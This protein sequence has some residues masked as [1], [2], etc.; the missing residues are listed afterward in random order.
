MNVRQNQIEIFTSE[1]GQTQLDVKLNNETVWLSQKELSLL[2]QVAVSTIN[3][4]IKNIFDEHELEGEAT[5]RKF[6]IVQQE[7]SRQVKREV[8]HY[9]LDMILSVGYRV[10]S[11]KA[12]RFRQW[13]T[14]VLKSYLSQGYVIN[15]KR[16]REQGIE[17]DQALALLSSTLRSQSQ[18]GWEGEAIIGVIQDYAR[19]W[20]L[21][22]QYDEDALSPITQAQQSMIALDYRE[23]LQ[24]IAA[25]KKELMVKSEATELFGQLRGGGLESAIG[26]IEQSFGGNDLY[27][28]VASRAAHLLYF[29]IK[30]HPFADGNKRSGSFLF[31]W[32]LRRNA[33]HLAKP[34][35]QLINDNTL[36]ALALLVA[37]SKPEHKELMIS[38][39][40]HFILLKDKG[41]TP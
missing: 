1:D 7:G 22:Q 12:T 36:V 32:Y 16:L 39:I 41:E 29:V 19:S 34:V 27:P 8:E 33:H 21:L 38:L 30:N 2:Y 15:E 17:F 5:I 20:S 24:A 10:N 18:I 26:T 14:Q 11:K 35:D 9:N 28:N 3:E 37:E 25:L 6:R 13:A 4:H 31:L 40:E 23:A